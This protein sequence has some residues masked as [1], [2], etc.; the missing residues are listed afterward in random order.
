MKLNLGCGQDKKAG[1]VN[2]DKYDSFSAD[3]I[4][5]LEVAPW[6]FET[7]SAEEIVLCH[8][9]EH[10]GATTDIFL[11]IMK[12]LYRICAPDGVV[13]IT[14]PH[15]RS[16]G[17]QGDP[18]H[19]RPINADVLSLFSKKNNRGWQ[20]KN[21]P[22][23][24]LATYLDINFETVD[25]TYSFQSPWVEQLQAGSLSREEITFAVNTYFN[26]VGE[27]DMTL[28]ARK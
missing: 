20:E 5:D 26:V 16:D 1:Y 11:S 13:H 15:P 10:L 19:V 23:T 28:I 24:R 27:I 17:F 12:E 9:L 25:L 18:T 7:S 14:V 22:N 21:W 3:V 6:P 2:V 4:W 8:V